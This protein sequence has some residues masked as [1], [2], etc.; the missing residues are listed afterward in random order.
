MC[1]KNLFLKESFQ[2]EMSICELSSYTNCKSL[3]NRIRFQ[4]KRIKKIFNYFLMKFTV[5]NLD[6]VSYDHKLFRLGMLSRANVTHSID[7]ET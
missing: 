4:E 1:N 2:K 6:L 3:S 7:D 5:C